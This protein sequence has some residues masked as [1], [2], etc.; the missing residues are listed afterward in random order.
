M[1]ENINKFSS[2]ANTPIRNITA[3]QLVN[4]MKVGWNLGNTFDAGPDETYWG[5]PITT[6]AMIDAIKAEGFNTIRIPVTWQYHMGSA[7][8]YTIDPAW[9]NRI[10]EVINYAFDNNMYVIINTH[11]DGWVVPTYENQ[12]Q[13]TDE[14]TKVW[15]QIA[16]RYKDYSDYLIFE[17]LNEPRQIEGPNEWTGGTAE[18]R[19]VINQYNLAAVNAIRGTGGN[20]ESRFIMVPTIAA[21]AASVAVN[22]LVIPNND[23]KIIVSLHMYTPCEFSTD[24]NSTFNWGSD[25]D[26]SSLEAELDAVYNKFVKN[27][28]AVVIGEFGTFNKD[29]PSARAVHAQYFVQVAK[30]NGMTAIWWDN[31][32]YTAGIADTFGIFNRNTLTWACPK[33]AE[34]IVSGAG[35]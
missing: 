8:N 4:D 10:E 28:R 7:P 18:N 25:S 34:A 30:S 16:N 13:V 6:P 26:K 17:T 27:G 23:S 29:N 31:G 12:T 33:V 3:L 19:D 11:H 2:T 5:N 20:N 14:L 24:I 22:D 1:N 21:C 9:F 35:I 32:K 15:I